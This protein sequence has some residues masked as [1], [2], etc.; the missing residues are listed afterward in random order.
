MTVSSSSPS[1]SRQSPSGVVDRRDDD[2]RDVV[3]LAEAADAAAAIV[4]HRSI[5][6][7]SD[8]DQL[9]VLAP[10]DPQPVADLAHRGVRP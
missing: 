6:P 9:A 10:R 1:M 2:Q 4:R 3:D 8:R 7:P 5:G